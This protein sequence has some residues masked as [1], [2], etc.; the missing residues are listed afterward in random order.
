[1]IAHGKAEIIDDYDEKISG[2]KIFM[3]NYS[4]IDF[5]FSK[6]SVD[7]IKIIKIEI[8]KLSGRQFEYPT[9]N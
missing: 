6:P 9:I 4:D 5:K 3:K 1:V 8:E 7:N 2:L